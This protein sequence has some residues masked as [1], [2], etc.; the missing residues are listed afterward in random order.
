MMRRGAEPA[1]L[2]ERLL[3]ETAQTPA[4]LYFEGVEQ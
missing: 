4:Q 3:M 2:L 1:P